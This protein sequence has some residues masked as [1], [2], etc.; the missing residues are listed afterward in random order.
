MNEVFELAPTGSGVVWF[1]SLLILFLAGLLSLFLF[2]W[3]SSSNSHFELND[4]EL[5]LHGDLWGRSIPIGSLRTDE[6]RILD[7]QRDEGLRP[8]RRTMGTGMPGYSSGWFKLKNGEKA[9]LY[10]SNRSKSV[11]IPTTEGYSLLLSPKNPE[12]FLRALQQSGG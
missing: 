5:S 3:W 11:Y 12:R 2:L 1:F 8:A 4:N 9:L 10:V 6:A 7:L